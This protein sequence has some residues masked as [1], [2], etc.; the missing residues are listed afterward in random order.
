MTETAHIEP[1]G[2]ALVKAVLIEPLV[3]DGMKRPKGTNAEDHDKGLGRLAERLAYLPREQ[4]EGLRPLIVRHSGGKAGGQWPD[5]VMIEKWAYA[6]QPPP[7]REHTYA[8]SLIR[9]AMGRQAMDEGWVVELYRTALRFGP[10]PARYVISQLRQEAEDNRR[11]RER[12]KEWNAVGRATPAE[13][14][15]LAAWHRDYQMC[16]AI[17][18][19]ARIEQQEGT[20]G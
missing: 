13:A 12:A 4:L 9:S 20:D 5:L 15:W 8:Q 6:I 17:I 10:P 2:R 18:E 14:E 11:R 1:T 16:A 3:R 19:A 7:P